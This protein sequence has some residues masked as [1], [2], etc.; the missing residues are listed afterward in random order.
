MA[1][2]NG[3]ESTLL[4]SDSSVNLIQLKE[5]NKE[6][7]DDLQHE[8]EVEDT[9]NVTSDLTEKVY[10][11][12]C[13]PFHPKCLQILA[14]KKFFTFLLSLFAFLQ[15]SIVSG[16]RYCSIDSIINPI[17]IYVSTCIYISVYAYIR[18]MIIL[19]YEY[20]KYHMYIVHI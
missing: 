1:D 14:N 12:G 9:M 10:Y 13:G 3:V 8:E 15:G 5:I 6:S 20:I 4:S 11:Y 2:L 18:T 19:M 16:M 17:C 7:D